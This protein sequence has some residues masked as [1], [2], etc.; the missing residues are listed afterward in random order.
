MR[1]HTVIARLGLTDR[2]RVSVSE[3]TSATTTL[4]YVLASRRI[5]HG[6]GDTIENLQRFGVSPSEPAFDLLLIAATVY[7]AD[8]RVNRRSES[9]DSWSR[10]IDIY[11]PVADPVRW[12]GLSQQLC[13]ML[14][15][16]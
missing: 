14:E 6:L 2:A 9:Q 4:Q 13:E 12:S 5:D 16:L 3:P 8:T 15:F 1:R 10:E 7:C 11:V